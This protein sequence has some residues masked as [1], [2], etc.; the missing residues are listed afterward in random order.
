MDYVLFGIQ[1]S[2]KGTQSEILKKHLHALYFE[3]GGELRRLA[4]EDSELGRK[5][6]SIIEAGHLVNTDTV[7]EIVENFVK[8]NANAVPSPIIFDGIPRNKEQNEKFVT[9]LQKLDRKFTG[10][11]FEL[12]RGEAKKRLLGRRVCSNCKR[13]HSSAYKKEVC[14]KCGSKLITRA[15]DNEK[16]IETRLDTFEKET[17]PIINAWDS[18]NRLIKVDASKSVQEVTNELMSK[19]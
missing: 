11:Y 8:S 7:M 15:D 18:A 13:P 19:L 17:S 12:S 4:Q 6:K 3:T 2:G 10:I 9:L 5:V 16:S 1:G 14:E